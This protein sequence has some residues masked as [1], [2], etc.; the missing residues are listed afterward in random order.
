MALILS[1][2]PTGKI[3]LRQASVARTIKDRGSY[4]CSSSFKI[5]DGTSR[6]LKLTFKR[7]GWADL[8]EGRKW[9]VVSAQV[10]RG[11]VLCLTLKPANKD[12][13][14]DISQII[15]Q[16]ADGSKD[17]TISFLPA[18]KTQA[19]GGKHRSFRFGP[20]PSSPESALT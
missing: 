5:D 7:V 8:R 3:L 1:E 2:N 11:E 14:V 17:V 15:G 20:V 10:Q 19:G 13:V 18:N 12:S 16:L 9:I 6:P 4:R